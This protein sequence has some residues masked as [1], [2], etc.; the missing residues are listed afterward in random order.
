LNFFAK[1]SLRFIAYLVAVAYLV[2]DLYLFQGPLSKRISSINPNS[3]ESIAKAKAQ[4]V[5]ARVF[6]HQIT[7]GQLEYAIHER[8]WLEGKSF[9][10]LKASD[11]KLV[12]Y[13]ALG[14]LIDHELLR[15]KTKVNTLEL[16][17]PDA[18]IDERYRRF[19]Q[20]FE[21]RENLLAAMKG[22]GISSETELRQRIAAR[23]QQE[24][25]IAM[26]IEPLIEV[27]SE[28]VKHFYAENHQ[29]LA[30]PERIRASHIFIA[31]LD[32]APDAGRQ[33]L[34][35]ALHEL[36]AGKQEFA[37]L[38]KLLSE[39]ES[40]KEKG[41]DLGWMSRARLPDDFA[42]AVFSLELNRPSLISTK[43]G[44]H[45]VCVTERKPSEPR[46]LA[47]A[48][49]EIKNAIQASKRHQAV[50]RFRAALRRFE[51]QKINIFHDQLVF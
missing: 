6:N 49:Q 24:K 25:Y 33:I 22:M 32:K 40:N 44:W 8:L 19:A 21:S 46:S 38:A 34:E 4:G 28:E 1:F 37:A 3:P 18:E 7:R 36:L 45:I 5:V 14:D 39:D 16:I 13:A 47:D 17:I 43:L 20:R 48:E 26:R 15:V 23:M 29:A 9:S 31:N 35:P 27:S 51:A 30:Y 10:D 41:G 2:G 12:T 11:R 42:A 50:D